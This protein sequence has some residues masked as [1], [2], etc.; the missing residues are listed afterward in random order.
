MFLSFEFIKFKII[1][2]IVDESR[3][4]SYYNF[5]IFLVINFYY[6]ELLYGCY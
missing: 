4:K 1:R 3:I 6:R 5:N 2:I